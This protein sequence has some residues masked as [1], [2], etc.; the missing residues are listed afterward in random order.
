APWC[1][2][3][4]TWLAVA[5]LVGW[6]WWMTHCIRLGLE[7]DPDQRQRLLRGYERR[8]RRHQLALFGTYIAAMCLFGWGWAVGEFWSWGDGPQRSILP[9]AELLV[10]SPFLA[11]MVLS[12]IVFY[13]GDRASYL[14]V[15]Q[16]LVLDP[17]A[18]ALLDQDH[19]ASGAA[20]PLS[21]PDLLVFG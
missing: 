6:A 20:L 10:L 5:L 14:A 4:L 9:G 2:A 21:S 13:D 1:S 17:L 3:L 12:W 8:R 7:Q 11:A 19:S 16:P 18:R 15:H